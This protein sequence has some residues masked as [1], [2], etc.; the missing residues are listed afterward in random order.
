M[1]WALIL[2]LYLLAATFCRL[3]ITFASGLETEGSKS[4]DTLIVF[5]KDFFEKVNF[6]KKVS[7][8]QQKHEKLPSL[9]R[10]KSFDFSFFIFS[11]SQT[12]IYHVYI[13]ALCS[14]NVWTSGSDSMLPSVH[15]YM[16]I[17]SAIMMADSR[18][19]CNKKDRQL[20][21]SGVRSRPIS[22]FRGDW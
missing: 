12:Y 22:H 2:T 3:L 14:A 21:V 6:W 10:V 17:H 7:I 20:Q 9:Q 8:R 5:L 1:A 13:D 11:E 18:Y 16:H 15:G 4:F 19:T